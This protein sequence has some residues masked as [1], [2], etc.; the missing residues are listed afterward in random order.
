[1]LNRNISI[2]NKELSTMQKVMSLFIL[3]IVFNGVSAQSDS[4]Y[5][6]VKLS[7]FDAAS[8]NNTATL[9]WSTVCYLQYA[10]FQIQ[11]SA[12]G[13][14]YKTIHSFTADKYR[15]SQPFDFIDHS[16]AYFGNV[17]YRIN[18]GNLN[19]QFFSSEVRRVHIKEQEF[20][21]ISV[22][23]TITRSNL[24]VSF[25]NDKNESFSVV[26]I[27]AS[28]AV[29]KKH[30]LQAVN[31]IARFNMNTSDLPSGYYVLRVFNAKGD[32]KTAR[33]IRQY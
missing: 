13:E 19:G 16:P 22:Y 24:K 26:I 9:H 23:P 31:G 4:I 3:L 2:H 17:F 21:L 18:V 5:F 15:C 1:M 27:N 8:N 28:G 33:F 25:S 14:N 30:Q 20:N 12:D 11:I 29:V 7:S 32:S 6:P 10:N